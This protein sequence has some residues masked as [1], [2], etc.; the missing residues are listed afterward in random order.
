MKKVQ[1][2]RRFHCLSPCVKRYTRRQQNFK[3]LI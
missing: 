1:N 3:S 2:T